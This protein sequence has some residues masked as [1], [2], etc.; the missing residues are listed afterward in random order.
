MKISSTNQAMAIT[1]PRGPPLAPSESAAP[2]PLGRL[3]RPFPGPCLGPRRG[4]TPGATVDRGTTKNGWKTLTNRG[5]NHGKTQVFLVENANGK[6]KPWQKKWNQLRWHPK[7]VDALIFWGSNL[8]NHHVTS[9]IWVPGHCDPASFAK[10][11]NDSMWNSQTHNRPCQSWK[12]SVFCPRNFTGEFRLNWNPI[13]SQGVENHQFPLRR[14]AISAIYLGYPWVL[15]WWIL[16]GYK[17]PK[18]QWLFVSF[19]LS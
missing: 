11:H 16:V 13:P 8:F 12:R 6:P 7:M 9:R 2:R 17:Y 14:T 3:R 5:R 18:V 15:S 19:K 10:T 1:S 4:V